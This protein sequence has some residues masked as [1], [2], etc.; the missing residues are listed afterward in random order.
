MSEETIIKKLSD[1]ATVKISHYQEKKV[2]LNLV[3]GNSRTSRIDHYEFITESNG[4]QKKT[5]IPK[6][7]YVALRAFEIDPRF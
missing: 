5:K 3:T 7:L 1:G 6:R 4:K 2:S